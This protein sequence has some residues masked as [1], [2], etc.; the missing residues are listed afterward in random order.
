MTVNITQHAMERIKERKLYP[1]EIE[2]TI[3]TGRKAT[4]PDRKCCLYKKHCQ[5]GINI[6]IT[7]L[8][9]CIITAYRWR[10]REKE[11]HSLDTRYARIKRKRKILAYRE[12][13]Y[14]ENC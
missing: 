1:E 9:G 14:S 2:E 5:S 3:K 10:L 7:G 12:D 6:V 11:S 8:D 13:D 4:R